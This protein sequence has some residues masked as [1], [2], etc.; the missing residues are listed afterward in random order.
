MLQ[1]TEIPVQAAG[2]K[3][4]AIDEAIT[5]SNSALIPATRLFGIRIVTPIDALA[6]VPNIPIVSVR[7]AAYLGEIMGF[8]RSIMPR[9][10]T[11]HDNANASPH[12][13]EVAGLAALRTK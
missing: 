12:T 1:T 5:G 7:I 3:A 2:A 10:S 13:T 8:K 4:I 11:S 6:T 9:K